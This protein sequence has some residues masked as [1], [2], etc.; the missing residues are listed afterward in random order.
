MKALI[1]AAGLGTRLRPYTE[2]I[3]KCLFPVAG[4]PNL[5]N[6]ITRLIDAGCDDI[7][8]NTHHLSSVVESYLSGRQYTVPVQTVHEPELLGTGGTIKNLATFW[9]DAPF[10]VI[11]G[12]V[13]CDVNLAEIYAFH[14]HHSHPVTICLVDNPE[15]NIVNVNP[16]GFITGF[17][18]PELAASSQDIIYKTFSGIQVLDKTVLDFIPENE[19]YSSIDAYQTM[20]EKGYGVKAFQPDAVY[21]N[22]IGSPERYQ[23]GVYDHM[24]TEAFK[25]AFP[26]S[27]VDALQKVRIKG[28][29]SDR[30]WYRLSTKSHTLIL[31]NHGIDPM[32]GR[33]EAEAFTFIG[34]HLY[35]KNLPVPKIYLY[36]T[37]SGLVFVEDLGDLDLETFVTQ[38]HKPDELLHIYETILQSL[39]NLS[40]NGKKDFDVS[41]TCQTEYYDV[42]MILELEC[43]Y[44]V[45]A[46]LNGYLNLQVDFK[47]LEKEF[48]SLARIAVQ[49]EVFG[50][51]HRDF[52]HRNIMVKNDQFYFIDFQGGRIGPITYDLASLL[53]DP[54]VDV[55]KSLV[56][57]LVNFCYETYTEQT[58]V[59]KSLFMSSYHAC[60]LTRNLQILGAYSFLSQKKNK[61]EFEQYIPPALASL[62]KNLAQFKAADLSSLLDIVNAIQL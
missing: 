21:W 25:Q 16:D 22:D 61:P 30:T 1:L 32:E 15:F 6:I 14:R 27:D 59:D 17:K 13:I 18:R 29:G 11:N 49:P 35:N 52:Q 41:W 20:I 33:S 53:I 54:Y 3:P 57:H 23:Q 2:K 37:F 10:F 19:F 12:D 50:F 45:D 38:P 26:E 9:N 51:M 43:R 46:F 60:S 28:D 8:I 24:A 42:P 48:T 7:M 39:V 36:D 31:A 55:H 58:G 40:I 44:F 4:R 62:Q 5:D 34:N 47:V 56:P